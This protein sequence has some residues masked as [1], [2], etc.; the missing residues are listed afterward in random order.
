MQERIKIVFLILVLIQGMHSVEE[1]L[2]TLWEVLPAATFLCGLISSNLETGFLV[3]NVGLF[4]LGL[5]CWLIPV[6]RQTALAPI[7]ILF[8]IVLEL[9]NGILHTGWALLELSYKPG[10]ITAPLLFVTAAYLGRCV[11]ASRAQ[12]A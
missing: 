3:I 4:A 10:L 12:V 1:Y 5:L 9:M 6:R 11:I 7:V 8:W 2:G